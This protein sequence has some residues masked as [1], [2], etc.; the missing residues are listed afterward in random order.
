MP[1]AAVIA[2]ISAL[3][4][5]GVGIAQLLHSNKDDNPRPFFD[6]QDEYF[7]NRNIAARRASEGLTAGALDYYGDMAG[8]GLSGTSNAIL[9][10]GGNVND[11]T[12]AYDTYLQGIRSVAAKDSEI[13]NNNILTFL[14]KNEELAKQKVQQ[15]AINKYE[16]FK[17]KAAAKAQER[18]AGIQNIFGGLQ[19]G[20]SIL[21]AGETRNLYEDLLLPNRGMKTDES[22]TT[23]TGNTT[24]TE[25]GRNATYGDFVSEWDYPTLSE[26]AKQMQAAIQAEEIPYEMIPEWEIK[27]RDFIN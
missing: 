3:G 26:R 11:I 14:D 6:I 24:Y 16:P 19:E 4:K 7:E 2:G 5:A 1:A 20:A 27:M 18:A 15:W 9:Q 23:P 22:T 12:R 8:R 25:R 13:Q 10:G 21:A 17:D